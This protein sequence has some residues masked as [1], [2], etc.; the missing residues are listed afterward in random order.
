MVWALPHIPDQLQGL[1]QMQCPAHLQVKGRVRKGR[2]EVSSLD[3]ENKYKMSLPF[4]SHLAASAEGLYRGQQP[5]S[6]LSGEGCS[7]PL[8]SQAEE[9][10]GPK[11]CE[12]CDFLSGDLMGGPAEGAASSCPKICRGGLWKLLFCFNSS[13][14][15]LLL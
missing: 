5:T 12:P 1:G 2:T 10:R 15:S 4:R 7:S 9:T 11:A 13:E 6:Q 3:L 8:A 14:S